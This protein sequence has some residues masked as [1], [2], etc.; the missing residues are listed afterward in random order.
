MFSLLLLWAVITTVHRVLKLRLPSYG[1]HTSVWLQCS[2]CVGAMKC[3]CWGECVL[4]LQLTAASPPLPP[5]QSSESSWCTWKS[6]WSC[7]LLPGQ[8]GLTDSDPEDEWLPRLL[9]TRGFSRSLPIKSDS[10]RIWLREPTLSHRVTLLQPLK[11]QNGLSSD[12]LAVHFSRA[13]AAASTQLRWTLWYGATLL[14]Y[15]STNV[16]F[17]CKDFSII[18]VVHLHWSAELTDWSAR[19]IND[20][21]EVGSSWKKDVAL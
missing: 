9:G 3:S 11:S 1:R 8:T 16:T 2:V 19:R 17:R 7:L 10:R 13:A 20:S 12:R 21:L 15:H 5:E 6:A 4:C 14:Q 18:V